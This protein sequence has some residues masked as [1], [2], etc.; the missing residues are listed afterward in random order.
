L[1]LAF[2][3]VDVSNHVFTKAKPNMS[4]TQPYYHWMWRMKIH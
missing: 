1:R 2:I 4:D 3:F